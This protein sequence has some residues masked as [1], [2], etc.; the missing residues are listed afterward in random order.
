MGELPRLSMSVCIGSGYP[1]I[2][3]TVLRFIAGMT[4]ALPRAELANVNRP[5][6]KQALDGAACPERGKMPNH[7]RPLLIGQ[8]EL[9]ERLIE[10]AGYPRRHRKSFVVRHPSFS[11]SLPTGRS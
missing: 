9:G 1:S 3:V 4:R 5:F 11:I 7:C 10:S 8:I 6:W 2:R